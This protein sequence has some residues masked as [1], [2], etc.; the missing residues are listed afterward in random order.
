[1]NTFNTMSINTLTADIRLY[2]FPYAGGNATV[3]RDWQQYFPQHIQV[4]SIESPGRG[5]RCHEPLIYDCPTLVQSLAASVSADFIQARLFKPTLRYAFFGHSA[6]ARFGFSVAKLVT[7][8]LLQAPIHG[9]LSA[10]SPQ[11][12]ISRSIKRAAISDRELIASLRRLGGTPSAVL[13]D[14]EVMAFLLPILRADF[15]ASD[16][17]YQDPGQPV[18]FPLTLFAARQDTEVPVE[19]VWD[20]SGYTNATCRRV[21][22]DG[23]H[24]SGVQSPQ[25]TI[26][27]ICADL[28]RVA[29]IPQ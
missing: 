25:P 6:G 1:M 8:R 29:G 18:A 21:L 23:D 27:R 17:C 24:F 11:Q 2:C 19:N 12:N 7:E 22:L 14:P 26:A 16:G 3:F 13:A 28:E 9:F 10:N 5:A 4:R 20:W 15:N